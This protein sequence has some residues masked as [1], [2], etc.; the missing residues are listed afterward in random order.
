MEAGRDR[1]GLAGFGSGTKMSEPVIQPS[2]SRRRDPGR[3]VEP[4]LALRLREAISSGFQIAADLGSPAAVS[5]LVDVMVDC[6]ELDAED[7][8]NIARWRERLR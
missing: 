7:L 3:P 5:Y 4:G 2:A 6:N 1:G 8:A